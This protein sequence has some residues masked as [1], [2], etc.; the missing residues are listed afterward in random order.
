MS[1]A[2]FGTHSVHMIEILTLFLLYCDI[3][4]MHQ[5]HG[6][7]FPDVP[8]ISAGAFTESDHDTTRNVIG[9]RTALCYL[10]VI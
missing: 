4:S 10:A 6:S 3:F 9:V 5:Q 1:A 7:M 8:I 2:P